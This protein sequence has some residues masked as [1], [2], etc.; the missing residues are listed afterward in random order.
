MEGR[1]VKTGKFGTV[2]GSL[3]YGG[4]KHVASAVLEVA[5]KFPSI[6]SGVNLK[7][8]EKIIKK[9]ISKGLKVS[10]YDR[11]KEPREIKKK[12]GNTVPWGIKDSHNQFEDTSRYHIS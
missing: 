5:R 12:E 10:S 6:R 11:E 3:M 8:D 9:A 4:S 2:A 7:Y 1:I